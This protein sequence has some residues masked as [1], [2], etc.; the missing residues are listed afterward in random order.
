MIIVGLLLLGLFTG[1]VIWILVAGPKLPSQ[2]DAIIDEVINK[3]LPELIVGKTGVVNS[4]GL[5][6]WYESISPEG[7]SKGTVLLI[8]GMGGS[9]LEW[10]HKYVQEFVDSGY[11][12]IRYD[13]RG[14]GMSDWVA[15]WD[16]KNPYSI[17]DMAGDAVAV[18]DALKIKKT[19]VV[20]LSLG[21]MIAQEIAINHPHRIESL[22]LIMTSGH[23][24]DPDLPSITSQYFISSLIKGIPLFK[25]RIIGGEKNLIK[26]RVAKMISFTREEYLDIKEIAEIVIY[27]LRQRRGINIKAIFQHLAAVNISGS[28]YEMLKTLDIPTLVIHGTNDQLFPIEHGKKLMEVIPNAKGIWIEGMGHVFPLPNMDEI[29]KD[30][31]KHISQEER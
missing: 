12:V 2:T 7:Q 30:I 26:E 3:E 6:I 20:G 13:H 31:I 16:R 24:G 27:D 15:D 11:H 29:I 18:L 5:D 17:K 21:G 1:L 4:D 25:Y 14:T 28:R 23:V 10:P 22:T 9:A 8:M 19:H